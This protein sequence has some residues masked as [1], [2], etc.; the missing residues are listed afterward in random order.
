MRLLA[1][2]TSSSKYSVSEFSGETVPMHRLVWALAVHLCNKQ[3]FPVGSNKP[4]HHK[5]RLCHGNKQDCYTGWP[6]SVSNN[7]PWPNSIFPLPKI[8]SFCGLFLFFAANK[9]QILFF[10]SLKCTSPILQS[11][12]KTLTKFLGKIFLILSFIFN[13]IKRMRKKST[14]SNSSIRAKYQIHQIVLGQN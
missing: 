2:S 13:S 6:P 3:P 5:T 11:K 10:S 8:Q 14:F 4:H 9:C 7:I 12:S 1:G